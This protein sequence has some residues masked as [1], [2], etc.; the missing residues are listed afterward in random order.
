M[1]PH[2]SSTS[3]A[4]KINKDSFDFGFKLVIELPVLLFEVPAEIRIQTLGTP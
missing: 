2:I 4:D 3:G 1:G